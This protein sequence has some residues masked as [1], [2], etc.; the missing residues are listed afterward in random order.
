MSTWER[1]RER[2]RKKDKPSCNNKC[3]A[4]IHSLFRAFIQ[5]SRQT[6]R[7]K[8][9]KT[10]L[11]QVVKNIIRLSM[12]GIVK[13]NHH[14]SK[15]NTSWWKK[16][17]S[18]INQ[19]IKRHTSNS[20]FSKFTLIDIFS[21]QNHSKLCET[22]AKWMRI[23]NHWLFTYGRY[24]RVSSWNK[25]SVKDYNFSKNVVWVFKTVVSVK[26][27]N[28]DSVRKKRVK[29][30]RNNDWSLTVRSNFP[31]QNSSREHG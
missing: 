19:A 2:R 23:M 14:L 30:K 8:H 5:L 10:L 9:A 28:A 6:K 26:K 20:T 25:S 16:R 31:T 7:R 27:N 13:K 24:V 3:S 15:R 12:N 22:Y 1:P 17:P 4:C 21:F 29:V 18:P 11:S